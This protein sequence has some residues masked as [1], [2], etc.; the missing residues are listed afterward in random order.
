MEKKPEKKRLRVSIFD[1]II[2]A[3]VIVAAGLLIFF[4]RQ[5]GKSSDATVN[6]RPVHY[7]I[8][9]N[10]MVPGAAEKIRAGDTIMDSDKKF[11][12]G[13]VENVTI[14]PATS[15]AKDLETGD[16]LTAEVP[17]KELAL[18]ELV[19]DCSASESQIKAASGYVVAVG[20]EVHAAG[21]GYA[22]IGYVVEINREDVG[23]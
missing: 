7:T 11:I 3:V 21:P 18:I 8:E 17:D 4:W 16:T 12:M 9:L 1:V 14:G 10:G 20:K 5:S 2:I 13:T 15:A 22:G 23:K 6:T 19:C